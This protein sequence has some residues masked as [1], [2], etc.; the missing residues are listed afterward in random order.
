MSISRQTRYVERL[1]AIF[2]TIWL[3]GPLEI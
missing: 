3:D 2:M 1:M